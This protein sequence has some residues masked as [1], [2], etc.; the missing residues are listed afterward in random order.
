MLRDEALEQC[1]SFIT[2]QS[3]T[4]KARALI[5]SHSCRAVDPRQAAIRSLQQTRRRGPAS[6]GATAGINHS[7]AA[8]PI[9]RKARM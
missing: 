7:S 8:V 3:F 5:D 4:L 1:C 9:I 2:N 6:G